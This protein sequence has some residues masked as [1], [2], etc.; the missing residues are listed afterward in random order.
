MEQMLEEFRRITCDPYQ[1]LA[2]QKGQTGGK[3]I[4]C[5][6]MHV[7]EEIIHA[8]GMLPIVLL[9]SDD[10][11]IEGSFYL[12]RAVC[13]SL[14]GDL[15]M[16]LKSKLA[17][18]DGMIFPDCCDGERPLPGIWRRHQPLPFQHVLYIFGKVDSPTSK[19]YIAEQYASLRRALEQFSGSKITDE[20]LRE[21]IV[22]YN[23]NRELLRRLYQLRRSNPTLLPATDFAAVVMSSMLM[24]KED[25]SALLRPLLEELEKT[26]KPSAHRIKVILSGQLC[27]QPEWEILKL[28]DELGMAM[29]DDDLYVGRKYFYT[30]VNEYIDP[31]EALVNHYIDD[32]P[33]HTKY[34][35]KQVERH[36]D[37]L[38]ELVKEGEAQAVVTFKL[39]FCEVHSFDCPA[40]ENRLSA[41]GVPHML[42]ETE[43]PTA[44][45]RIRTQLEAFMEMLQGGG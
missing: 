36:A 32:V 18:L 38:L 11:I 9:G 25:H 2:E 22:T 4:G 26:S 3:I 30:K 31:I 7:P 24:P 1:R 20:A 42:I 33:C 16:A 6:P 12:A 15:G 23:Q 10:D 27:D 8:A 37:Y 19:R 5:L 35:P 41:A 21:S 39:R 17:F 28:M 40:I 43:P 45:G 34:G 13:H 14:R 44:V 29:V